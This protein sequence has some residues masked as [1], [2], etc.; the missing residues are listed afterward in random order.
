MSIGGSTP[1]DTKINGETS[2]AGGSSAGAGNTPAPHH[3]LAPPA[4]QVFLTLTLSNAADQSP[5]EEDAQLVLGLDNSLPGT[6]AKCLE[7]AVNLFQTMDLATLS[8][9]SGSARR[10]GHRDRD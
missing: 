8:V 1:I 7:A 4:L 2:N 5:M 6:S 10:R 9:A 3:P